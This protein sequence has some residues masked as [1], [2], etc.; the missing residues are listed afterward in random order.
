MEK[1]NLVPPRPVSLP[2]LLRLSLLAAATWLPTA[3]VVHTSGPSH[4]W[5]RESASQDLGCPQGKLTITH[6]MGKKDRKKAEGCG[7]TAVY[8]EVC[9]GQQ[10]HWERE[11]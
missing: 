9:Q 6:Y 1:S 5:I 2:P 3:C 10:C 7:K 11:P 4:D 8:R